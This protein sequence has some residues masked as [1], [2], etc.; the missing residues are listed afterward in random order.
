MYFT[1][2]NIIIFMW[3]CGL[4]DTFTAI[5]FIYNVGAQYGSIVT[6]AMIDGNAAQLPGMLF[7]SVKEGLR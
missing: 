1:S 4:V 7:E 6:A 2:L 3:Q 5:N